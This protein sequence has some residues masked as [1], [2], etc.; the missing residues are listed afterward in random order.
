MCLKGNP[1]MPEN[2]TK[3]FRNTTALAAVLLGVIILLL[4][5][6]GNTGAATNNAAKNVVQQST[7][8]GQIGA[9]IQSLSEAEP[10]LLLLFGVALFG[11]ATSLRWKRS[12]ASGVKMVNAD[13]VSLGQTESGSVCVIAE[14]SR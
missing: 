8:S 2:K 5:V 9:I 3:N 14:E 6:S 10:L 1:F 7:M 13:L 11:V 12:Q 4:P